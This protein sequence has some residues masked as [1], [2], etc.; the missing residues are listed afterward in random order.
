LPAACGG[1]Q[2]QN[3]KL[4]GRGKKGKGFREKEFLPRPRRRLKNF[5]I[6][7]IFYEL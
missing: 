2:E 3:R 1:G 4:L 7:F 6:A 5:I